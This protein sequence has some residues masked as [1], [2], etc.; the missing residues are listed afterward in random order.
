MYA[1]R[2]V[3]KGKG[4]RRESGRGRGEG[5]RKESERREGEKGKGVRK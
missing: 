1:P 2:E 5:V 3:E 4:E